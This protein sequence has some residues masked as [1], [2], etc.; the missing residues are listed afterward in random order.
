MWRQIYTVVLIKDVKGNKNEEKVLQET[1]P[2]DLVDNLKEDSSISKL[3]TPPH[4]HS[5][6]VSRHCTM[7]ILST[8]PAMKLA[9]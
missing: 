8:M 2:G 6:I 5:L 3:S 7:S 1:K 4:Q 9:Q